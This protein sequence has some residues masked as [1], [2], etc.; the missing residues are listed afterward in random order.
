MFNFLKGVIL[1][2]LLQSPSLNGQGL[3]NFW[4]TGYDVQSLPPWGNTNIDFISGI[5]NA[6]YQQRNLNF[7]RTSVSMSDSVGNLIFYSNGFAICNASSD[8][9]LNGGGLDSSSQLSQ[10]YQYG[11]PACQS[12]IIIP[13]PGLEQRIYNIFHISIDTIWNDGVKSYG[14][15]KRLRQTIIDMNLDSGFGGVTQREFP[16]ISDTLSAGQIQAVKHGN[17]RDWWIIFWRHSGDKVYTFLLTPMG[18]QSPFLQSTGIDLIPATL[19]QVTFSPDGSKYALV[20]HY[21][22]LLIYNFDRCTGVFSN[23]IQIPVIDSMIARGV[24]FSPNNRFLYMSSQIHLYQFDMWASNVAASQLTVA[25]YD[26]FYSPQPLSA[27]TFYLAMLANDNKIYINA[28]NGTDRMHIINSPDSL[29]LACN[30]CQHCLVLPT[31]NSFT[32]PNYPN[33]FLGA[34]MGSICDSLQVGI[35]EHNNSNN[36]IKIYPN[37]VNDFFWVDYDLSK[38]T[39]VGNLIVYNTIGEIVLRKTV[40]SYF[41][42]VK[43]DCNNL[44]E[45][46][47]YILIEKNNHYMGSGKFVKQ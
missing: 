27:T 26:S 18:I 1:F 29:G 10:W 32:M 9:M 7:D 44:A 47:Y 39:G 23:S 43:I 6:Y 20:D 3:C 15:A 46:I 19:R 16:I 22:H 5:P 45:G 30:V 28:S 24:A 12:M 31:Y 40:F 37:P 2:I 25:E 34:E 33:Y 17:G 41:K 35:I 4:I 8:T 42:S 13:Q 38:S 21:N 11:Q 14:A 36:T